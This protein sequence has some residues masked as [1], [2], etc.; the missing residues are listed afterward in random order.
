M[1][2]KLR[3]DHARLTVRSR[4]VVPEFASQIIALIMGP[5]TFKETVTMAHAQSVSTTSVLLFPC[6]AL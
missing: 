4:V 5:L 3:D 6:K 2:R 1:G